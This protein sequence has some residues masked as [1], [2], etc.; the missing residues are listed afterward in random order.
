[1]HHPAVGGADLV[2]QAQRPPRGRR[3][4]GSRASCRASSPARRAHGTTRAAPRGPP[5]R[6]GSGPGPVSPTART[7]SL[8]RASRSISASASSSRPSAARRGASLGCSATPAT[9]CGCASAVSTAQRAPSRSQPIWT[10]RV[11]PTD[12]ARSSASRTGSA[13]SSEP[14]A[15]S[16]W[17][18]LSTTGCGSASGRAGRCS[19]PL[20][21]GAPRRRRRASGTPERRATSTMAC[22]R[23]TPAASSSATRAARVAGSV[24]ASAGAAPADDDGH[25]ASEARFGPPDQLGQRAA[26]YLLVGLGQLA[27][28]RT[29]TVGAEH[30]GHRLQR[31]VGAVR[32]LE[33]DQGAFVARHGREPAGALPRLA[34]QEALEAEPVD[35]QA[36]DGE[37]RE[38]GRG[39]GHGGHRHVALD[40]GGDEPVAR[41]RHARHAGIGHEHHPVPG[42][43][44]LEQRRR[45]GGARCPR[46]RRPRDR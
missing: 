38:D 31:R 8:L 25:L 23:G 22:L 28:H 44:R 29:A 3:G 20:T 16:R 14:R 9:T 30:L 46:S 33:E 27:A 19:R 39:P 36:G 43:Q 5:R 34:W 41:V 15:M 17:Q 11:T 1:M 42:Q 40:R 35:G 37:R 18:W 32:R 26:A 45:C 24:T 10:T 7:R 6:C 21:S 13:G 2:Q 4:R 12:A